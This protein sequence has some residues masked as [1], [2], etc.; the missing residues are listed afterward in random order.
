MSPARWRARA[1][2]CALGV[3]LLALCAAVRAEAQRSSPFD[4]PPADDR[5]FVTDEAPLLDTSCFYRSDGPISYTIDVDRYVGPTNADGTLQNV[6]ALTADGIVSATA[7]LRMP[8]FDVDFEADVFPGEFPE[9]DRVFFNDVEIGLLTGEDGVWKL[10]AFE[11]PIAAVHFP[12]ARGEG[13]GRPLPAHNTVTVEIDT[14]N[15]DELWCTAI[16]WGTLNFRAIS[17]VVMVHGNNS[18]GGF[19]SRQ[20]FKGRLDALHIPNDNSINMV[21]SSVVANAARLDALI[22]PIVQSF[23]VDSI[24]LVAHS[25]GGLD[26]REFLATWAGGHRK[27]FQVLSLSTL[28]TPHGGS[29]GADFQIVRR[30]VS[31]IEGVGVTLNLLSFMPVDAGT[32][33]L[34]T[35]AAAAFNARNGPRLPHDTIYRAVGADA[36]LNGNGRM[37]LTPDEFA[38]DRSES[39]ALAKL[40]SSKPELSRQ[41][42]DALYQTLRNYASVR[43]ETRQV[44]V[45]GQPVA[46]YHVGVATPGGGP[47]DTLVTINSA[48]GPGFSALPSFTGSN[49]RDHATIGSADVAAV[50]VPQLHQTEAAI[51][52]FR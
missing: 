15:V 35:A 1:G 6:A 7:T 26:A 25:K 2:W 10:N 27:E 48:Q 19:F 30:A 18:D 9:R 22:P 39:A 21:T 47:N 28:S 29:V 42:V 40:Y 3:G 34:T 16:D 41:A 14:A 33:D 44:T 24:H 32:P 12:S 5:T 11:V 23:G 13:G 45:F 51:G 17:P 46:T 36:D 37:D 43:V 4:P 38:G 52:D 31:F 8:A 50:V 49:G 20:G